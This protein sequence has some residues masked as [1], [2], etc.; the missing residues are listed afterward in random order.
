M[1]RLAWVGRKEGERGEGGE[2][3]RG[4]K[5]SRRDGEKKFFRNLAK[6]V[7][8]IMLSFGTSLW[9]GKGMGKGDEE[10]RG[11]RGEVGEKGERRRWKEGRGKEGKGKEERMKSDG[12]QS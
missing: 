11:R 2:D 3:E 8:E 1:R 12:T 10:G 5:G 4:G 7:R 6:R 9:V